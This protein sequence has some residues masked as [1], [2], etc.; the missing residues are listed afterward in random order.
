MITILTLAFCALSIASSSVT[1]ILL[2]VRHRKM[3]E[4]ETLRSWRW[5]R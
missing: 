3:R 2:A 1:V 5:T 4:E